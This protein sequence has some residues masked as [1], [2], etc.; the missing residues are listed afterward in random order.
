MRVFIFFSG[1]KIMVHGN[2]DNNFESIY[3][4]VCSNCHSSKNHHEKITKDLRPLRSTYRSLLIGYNFWKVY[5]LM[6]LLRFPDNV[7]Y[8][9][10]TAYVSLHCP[11]SPRLKVPTC[12]HTVLSMLQLQGKLSRSL[13]E[14]P[15]RNLNVPRRAGWFRG[16]YSG[17]TCFSCSVWGISWVSWFSS[18]KCRDCTSIFPNLL[19]FD[20]RNHSTIMWYVE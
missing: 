5:C 19:Q 2:P 11:L 4:L 20:I 7:T 17:T 15:L 13:E 10:F 6:Q 9:F 12:L 18:R 14:E 1:L 16:S 8:N 3:L